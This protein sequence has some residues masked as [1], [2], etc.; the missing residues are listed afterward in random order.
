MNSFAT[1]NQFGF[2]APKNGADIEVLRN[3]HL[4]HLFAVTDEAVDLLDRHSSEQDS[5]VIEPL[6]STEAT[7]YS[8]INAEA[9]RDNVYQ[10]FEGQTNQTT[11]EEYEVA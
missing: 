7:G 11:Y 1:D 5:E 10:L 3:T 2:G 8:G 4:D 6:V 9:A